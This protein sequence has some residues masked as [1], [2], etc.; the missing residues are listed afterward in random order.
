M[1]A[2]VTEQA[3]PQAPGPDISGSM[4]I[5]FQTGF[6][7]WL[8]T[9]DLSGVKLVASD[10]DVALQGGDLLGA[11]CGKLPALPCAPY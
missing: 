2:D 5:G 11:R 6:L 1:P 4:T 9:Q 3:E 8:A 10:A 7:R